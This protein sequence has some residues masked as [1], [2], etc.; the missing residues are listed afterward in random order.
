MMAIEQSERYHDRKVKTKK[1]NSVNHFQ[2]FLVDMTVRHNMTKTLGVTIQ[3][4]NPDNSY[5]N[6][7]TLKRE[8]LKYPQNH[9]L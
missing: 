5:L 2:V 3:I 4:M 7:G 8:R 9:N 6:R 1:T